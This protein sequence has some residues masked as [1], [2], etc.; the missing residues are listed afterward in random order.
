[1]HDAQEGVTEVVLRTGIGSPLAWI[2][3]RQ[4]AQLALLVGTNPNMMLTSVH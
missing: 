2:P 4:D 1:M 3:H